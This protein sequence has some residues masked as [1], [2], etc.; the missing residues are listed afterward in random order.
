MEC[1]SVD[2]MTGESGDD[3]RRVGVCV[4]SVGWSGIIK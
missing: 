3:E 1:L 4:C 2:R